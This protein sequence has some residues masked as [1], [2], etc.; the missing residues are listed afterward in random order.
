MWMRK[1]KTWMRP[2]DPVPVILNK[3]R[4]ENVTIYGAI[5]C[6][7]SKALF[8]QTKVTNETATVN[9][10]QK[11][12][13]HANMSIGANDTIHLILDNHA[14][15][16]TKKVKAAFEQ[17]NIVPHFMPPYSPQFNSIEALWGCIKRNVKNKLAEV[18]GILEQS[19]FQR[20]LENVY[21]SITPEQQAKAAYHNNRNFLYK[22]I[23]DII[24]RPDPFP[25]DPLPIG[26]FVIPMPRPLLLEEFDISRMLV[27]DQSE[28]N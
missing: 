16:H 14:A 8:M 27:C 15:H 28:S 23:G 25:D 24:E 18:P 6:C 22:L 19:Q 1:N 4:G 20:I 17:F 3:N 10:M 7:L 2:D 12:R 26:D 5:G 9:F 21:D 11:L 13:Q